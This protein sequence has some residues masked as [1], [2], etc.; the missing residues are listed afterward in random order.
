[1][2]RAKK[3]AEVG[4]PDISPAKAI[5][6]LQ[7]H[8]KSG[9]NLL[10]QPRLGGDEYATWTML[11]R[12]YLEKA[13]GKN[14]PN[15]TSVMSVGRYGAFPMDADEAWWAAHRLDA[16]SLLQSEPVPSDS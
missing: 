13:F 8:L 10:A 16:T 11:A 2:A 5:E 1:M 3:P 7:R 4:T 12:N 6:L 15:V 14:S 9:D